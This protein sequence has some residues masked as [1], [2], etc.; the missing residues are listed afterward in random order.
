MKFFFLLSFFVFCFLKKTVAQTLPVEQLI[1]AWKVD[2]TSQTQKAEVIIGDQYFNFNKQRFAQRLAGINEYIQKHPNDERIKARAIIYTIAGKSKLSENENRSLQSVISVQDQTNLMNAIKYADRINDIQLLSELYSL[3]SRI[4]GN[5]GFYYFLKSIKLQEQVG[6]R[7]FPKVYLRYFDLSNVL[8]DNG[9][10]AEAMT[11]AKKALEFINVDVQGMSDI[12]LVQDYVAAS[13]V[14][15][16]IADSALVYFKKMENSFPAVIVKHNDSVYTGTWKGIILGGI[17]WCLTQKHQYTDALPYLNKALQLNTKYHLD[18]DLGNVYYAYALIDTARA[19]YNNALFNFEK[20][21]HYYRL[22]ADT[23]DMADALKEMVKIFARK[24]QYD[25]AYFYNNLY[26]IC[27]IDLA[28]KKSANMLNRFQS[29]L[30]FENTVFS[31]NNAQA[32]I[33]S[34]KRLHVIVAMAF[35]FLLIAVLMFFNRYRLKKTYQQKQLEQKNKIVEMEME[36]ARQ[37]VDTFIKSVVGKDYLIN[38]LQCQLNSATQQNAAQLNEKFAQYTFV[39]DEEW[40]TFKDE[41]KKGYPTFFP[42]LQSIPVQ[43]NPA[44]EKLATLIYLQLSNQQIANTL[45]IA[46]ESVARA[47]RRLKQKLNLEK[48]L[49]LE[50]YILSI[51][52]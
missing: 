28:A 33:R 7:F 41:F 26:H 43:L 44:E 25:S 18:E 10:Y 42:V 1:K 31:L 24:Q 52:K 11:Y 36:N 22:A 47:K 8:Y 48:S 14:K 50:D 20:A 30:L 6:I 19:A 15:L 37:Q 5:H 2:D 21:Y 38:E 17:G 23:S 16:G 39:V 12:L 29:Q 46:K 9:D 51:K 34:D 40:E 13:Y 49:L 45:G 4:E 35:I 32:T 27:A 3:Y